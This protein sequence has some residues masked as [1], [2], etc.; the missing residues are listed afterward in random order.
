MILLIYNINIDFL[1]LNSVFRII[2]VVNEEKKG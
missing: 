2:I 1:L